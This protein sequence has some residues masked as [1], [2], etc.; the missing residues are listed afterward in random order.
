V[1]A[2]TQWERPDELE[3]MRTYFVENRESG[4]KF[5][6]AEFDQLAATA[7]AE[8]HGYVE[9]L[10]QQRKPTQTLDELFQQAATTPS[11]INEHCHTLRRLASECQ[12]VTE[13][14][15]RHG[16]S[17][18][19]LLAAQPRELVLVDLQC[20]DCQLNPLKQVAGQT[21]LT[22]IQADSRTIDIPPTDLLFVDT[23]HTAEHI[24]D[25][26]KQ[27]D[28]V[29][30]YLVFHDTEIFGEVGEWGKPGILHAIRPFLESHPEWSI[31]EQHRNNHG[32]LV[33]RRADSQPEARS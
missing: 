19:A 3:R 7:I 18:V 12:H 23:I 9:S 30:R 24:A 13:F 29:A 33:L 28:K 6:E 21:K 20:Q 2:F 10:K 25:E 14:G 31:A 22:L 17:S 16:V 15:S 1:L 11:D 32:L 4:P 8:H 26:L 5:S 27:A